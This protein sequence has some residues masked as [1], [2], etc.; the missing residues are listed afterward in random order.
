MPERVEAGIIGAWTASHSS[1]PLLAN[2]SRLRDA[3]A[4]SR[5]P[6][7]PGAVAGTR[8]AAAS[9][10]PG[11]SSAV[12]GMHA[13]YEHS[14]LSSSPCTTAAVGPLARA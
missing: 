1:S 2:R 7:T 4:T 12:L 11:S 9:A 3:A 6:V 5:S 13:Q 14:P 8:R 10:S